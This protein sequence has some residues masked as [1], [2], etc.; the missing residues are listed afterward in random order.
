M[1]HESCKTSLRLEKVISQ[2]V[3]QRGENHYLVWKLAVTQENGPNTEIELRKFLSL[4][5][6]FVH[7]LSVLEL[8]EEAFSKAAYDAICLDIQLFVETGEVWRRDSVL[9][10]CEHPVF[11]IN[12]ESKLCWSNIIGKSCTDSRCEP[13]ANQPLF[14]AD[15]YEVDL[16]CDEDYENIYQ[17]GNW[18]V[19][20][21]LKIWT[22]G[23]D[24][25]MKMLRDLDIDAAL[26]SAFI[27]KVKDVF[28]INVG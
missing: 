16:W 27:V 21:V 7:K 22:A 28:G 13:P 18:T 11:W 26:K 1:S 4:E 15:G 23:I 19:K 2:Q 5:E 20:P 12:S 24:N 10:E 14:E 25:F 6:M 17:L 8:T 3:F 9:T